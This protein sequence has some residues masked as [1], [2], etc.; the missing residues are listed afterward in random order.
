MFGTEYLDLKL[1]KKKSENEEKSLKATG[2][3][4]STLQSLNTVEPGS[5]QMV[6]IRTDI[7]FHNCPEP[8]EFQQSRLSDKGKVLNAR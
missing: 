5:G 4:S 6:K 2:D 1:D 8:Q 7:F 3:R